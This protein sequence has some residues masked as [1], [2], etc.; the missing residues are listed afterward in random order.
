MSIEAWS[1]ISALVGFLFGMI[2]IPWVIYKFLDW[3]ESREDKV[4]REQFEK[5]RK[6]KEVLSNP[7]KAGL[8]P[9][10]FRGCKKCGTFY[11]TKHDECPYCEH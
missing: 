3:M 2:V 9:T 1:V 6:A 4:N 8:Q 5:V 7:D 10:G 11:C